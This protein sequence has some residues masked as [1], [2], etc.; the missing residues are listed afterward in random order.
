MIQQTIDAKKADFSESE[1]AVLYPQIKKFIVENKRY[2]NKNADDELESEY[3][4]AL[5]KIRDLKM[6]RDA[7]NGRK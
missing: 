1:L 4:Y 7:A 6:R 2:P 5:A 3:A